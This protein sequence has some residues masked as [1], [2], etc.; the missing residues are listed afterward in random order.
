MDLTMISLIK[1]VCTITKK[2]KE[3]IIMTA[4]RKSFLQ[5]V[6]KLEFKFKQAR[7]EERIE[8]KINSK[9]INRN[10]YIYTKLHNNVI[11]LQ[12]VI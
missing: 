8:S 6:V 3:S 7:L 2:I 1:L 12:I 9:D 11:I 5:I 4:I 10:Q